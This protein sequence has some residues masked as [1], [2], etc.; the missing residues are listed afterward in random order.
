VVVYVNVDSLKHILINVIS[1]AIQ[2]MPKGGS[3]E[4][5]A[6]PTRNKKWVEIKIT[7]TGHGI[8]KEDMEKI[9][10]PYFTTK[11]KGIGLGLWITKNEVE[12]NGGRI[13]VESQPGKHTTFTIVLP[14]GKGQS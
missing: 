12:G 1:N 9:F 6:R 2:A 5:T 14:S 10:D 4:I 13:K 8:G 3:L 11:E 7:D